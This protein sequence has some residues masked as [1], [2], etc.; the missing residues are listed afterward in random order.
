MRKT[1]LRIGRYYHPRRI[2]HEIIRNSSTYE[3]KGI[4]VFVGEHTRCNRHRGRYLKWAVDVA[5]TRGEELDKEA[6]G[7]PIP[8]KDT[9]WA[10]H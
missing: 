6:N 7:K 8:D 10:K 9:A 4:Y 5:W 2:R 1:C 3:I